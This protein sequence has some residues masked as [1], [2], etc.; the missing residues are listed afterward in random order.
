MDI[1]TTSFT[2]P[3]TPAD[4]DALLRSLHAVSVA[5]Y[6]LP[7]TAPSAHPANFSLSGS[8]AQ[9]LFARALLLSRSSP[10]RSSSLKVPRS[11][12]L[13]MPF[14]PAPALNHKVRAK[15]D[16]IASLTIAHIAVV[17]SP[18]R[19]TE[20]PALGLETESLCELVISGEEDAVDLARVRLLVMLDELVCLS[21][22]S[23]FLASQS[24]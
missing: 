15:L 21:F 23:V 18:A 2:V 3:R 14:S 8:P 11:L 19:P 24:L 17:N 10:V 16:D 9:V 7:P 20:H 22:I 5:H 1:Y 6:P 4:L 13:D 12:I